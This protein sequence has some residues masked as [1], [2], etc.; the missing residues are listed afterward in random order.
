MSFMWIF[1]SAIVQKRMDSGA[2]KKSRSL[3]ERKT[4]KHAE[5]VVLD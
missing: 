1:A 3:I 4:T 5:Y 2:I